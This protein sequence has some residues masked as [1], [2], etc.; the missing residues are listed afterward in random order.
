LRHLIRLELLDYSQLDSQAIQYLIAMYCSHRFN[1][2]GSGWIENSCKSRSI[3]VEG[4]RYDKN[5][6]INAFDKEGAWINKILRKPHR[7]TATTIWRNVDPAYSPIDWQKDIRSG[8]RW[9]ARRWYKDQEYGHLPGVDVKVPLEMARMHHLPQMAL[10]SLIHKQ[11]QKRLI[12]EFK[13]QALDF[14]AM[15]PPRMGINWFCTMDVAIRAVNMLV[16]YDLFSQRDPDSILSEDFKDVFVK[17]IYEHGRHIIANL[18]YSMNTTNHY[19]A[20]LAGLLFIG[21]YIE[22]NNEADTW[23]CLAYRQLIE[24]MRNQFNQDG[25]NREGSTCYHALSAE[26]MGY[27]AALIAGLSD[28]KKSVLQRHFRAIPNV[29]PSINRQCKQWFRKENPEIF[30]TWFCERLNKINHILVCLCKQSN[31]IPQIGDNDSGRFIR[32]FP[33][34]MFMS[35]KEA[36]SRYDNLEG[37]SQPDEPYY[38]ET[39]LDKSPHI[40]V[41][42]ALFAEKPDNFDRN[43]KTLEFSFIRAMMNRKVLAELELQDF[44]KVAETAKGKIR[45]GDLSYKCDLKYHKKIEIVSLQ[46]TQPFTDGLSV[47]AFYDAGWFL[48]KSHRLYFLVLGEALAGSNGNGHSH[49]DRLSFELSIDGNDIVVDPGTYTYTSLPEQRNIFRSSKVHN[50]LKFSNWEPAEIKSGNRG[51]FELKNNVKC[52]LV[53]LSTNRITLIQKSSSIVQIRQVSIL[54]DRIIIEDWSNNEFDNTLN[55]FDFYSPGYGI[56][57]KRANQATSFKINYLS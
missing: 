33:Y 45:P 40:S 55:P 7:D 48:F 20:N 57:A 37:Y 52:D 29:N 22:N 42:K 36:V 17:S 13:H 25:T 14:I 5:I 27:C 10:F 6:D 56:I 38:D 26:I 3:G 44:S 21:A 2:L 9:D 19:L 15:N 35:A 34:G 39:T 4:H 30:P 43:S 49:N 28:D 53:D 51:L 23:L 54:K 12:L 8:Y 24:E 41:L 18:E 16:A 50:S 1:L 11:E 47:H 46:T 31:E 32:L